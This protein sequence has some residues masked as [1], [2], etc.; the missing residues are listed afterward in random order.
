MIAPQHHTNVRKAAEYFDEHLAVGDYYSENQA[1]RGEWLGK[2]AHLLGLSGIVGKEEFVRLCENL[3]PVTGGQLTARTKTKRREHS[4][5]GSETKVANRR[6]F[7][8]FAISPPKSVS[9]AALVVGDDRLVDSHDRAVRIAINE[10]ERFSGTRVRQGGKNENRPTGNTITAVFRHDTSRALDPHLH[11]HCLVFNAT[12][13]ATESRWK[14]LQT[15]E[16]FKARKYV[17]NVYY[18]ELARDLR[19]FGYRIRNKARGD[20]EVEG[21]PNSIEEKFSKRHREINEQV[22]ELLARSPQLATRNR[23]AVRE[24]VAHTQRPWKAP[25]V[26]HDSLRQWWNDQLSVDERQELGR[27]SSEETA[28]VELPESLEAASALHWAEEHVFS[29]KTLVR[30]HELWRFALE[31]GRGESFTLEALH[32]ATARAEYIRD[33]DKDRK[34]TTF[35]VLLREYEFVNMASEGRKAC[36]PLVPE[37]EGDAAL[38]AGQLA[39]ARKILSSEDFAILFRGGAG[40]GKSFTLRTVHDTLKAHGHAVEVL[41]PQRQQVAGLAEDGMDGAQTVS[42]FLTRRRMKPGAAVIVDEAGQIG[43]KDMHALVSFVK[44]HGGRLI[45]SG[46]TRQHGAVQASDA[47]WAIEKYAHLPVAEL[48]EIRRQDP[49]RARDDAERAWITEYKQA[50]TEASEGKIAESF[51]RLDDLGAIVECTA[52]DQQE[53]LSQH[54]LELAKAGQSTLVVSPTWGEIHKVNDK[55]REGLQAAGLLGTEEWQVSSLQAVDLSD[56]QKRDARYYGENAVI[57]FNQTAR[58]APKGATGMLIAITDESIV[59][60]AAGKIRDVPFRHAGKLTVCKKEEMR[61]SRGDRLQ[62]KANAKSA[63]GERL[64]N[65]ELV[66]VKRVKADGSIRLDDGRILPPDFRQFVRGYAVTSYASQGKTVD[67]VL[68]SDSCVKA[69]TNARQ[70]YVTISRGRHTVKVFTTD[71]NQLR[72]NITR[73]G[74]NELALDLVRG[75]AE[76][77]IAHRK[78][79]RFYGHSTLQSLILALNRNH[80]NFKAFRERAKQQLKTTPSIK[81]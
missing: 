10:L 66:T 2:G 69:A 36:P 65:G 81:P 26:N 13:D 71:K 79:G 19:R 21:L 50:V 17:E 48:K 37:W 34:L 7:Y 38:D 35:P 4:G 27:L 29:R 47:L 23:A 70:W 56:A 6:L 41:A 11:S 77:V 61:L 51:D 52:A 59:V 55:V 46:D 12:F 25:D 58:G 42:T 22:R 30:E 44:D 49:F 5:D 1:V 9:I 43:G 76:S 45:F 63:E 74:Q 68:F 20:F 53:K 31:R 54:Y 15:E 80:R 32:A 67:H 8:D 64:M 3:H 78:R 16:M 62:L 75:N 40:T 60:E 18:H 28:K 24:H 33:E 39:A 72:E 73:S 57:V 14:A